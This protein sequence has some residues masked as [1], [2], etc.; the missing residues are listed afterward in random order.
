MKKVVGCI[1]LIILLLPVNVSAKR[2][3]CSWHGGVSGACRNGYQVCNDGTTSPSCTC[4]GGTSSSSSSSTKKVYTPSYIYGCTNKNALN[5]NPSANKDDGSCIQKVL[6]CTDKNAKNYNPNANKDDGS[7]IQKVLGCTDKNAKNYNSSANTDD[8]TC[9][10][11]KEITETKKIKYSTKYIDNNDMIQGEE[12]VKTKG[13]NGEKEVVYLIVV[14]KDGKELTREKKS[15]TITKETITEVVEKGTKEDNNIAVII[16][17]I[18]LIIVFYQAFKHKDGNLLLNKIQTKPKYLSILL[19]ILY[20]ITV[21]P[22][23]IDII[24]MII[25]KIKKSSKER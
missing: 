21:I 9:Q 1:L 15:E 20:I 23:F 10:Y 2:G 16:T 5:Y 25:N 6:G 7:C 24:I 3:C 8:N 4:S 12:K 17:F 14:D 19:Y 18:C 22:I 13:V 11:E